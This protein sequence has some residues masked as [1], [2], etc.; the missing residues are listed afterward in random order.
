MVLFDITYQ[1][2]GNLYIIKKSRRELPEII[3]EDHE[4]ENPGKDTDGGIKDPYILRSYAVVPVQRIKTHGRQH[5]Q[6]D[7]NKTPAII[8]I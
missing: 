4:H 2:F 7:L 6:Q 8:P 1:K 5:T 3:K